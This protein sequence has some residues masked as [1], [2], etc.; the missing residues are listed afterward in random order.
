METEKAS[1]RSSKASS[2]P[3]SDFDLALTLRSGQV[4][5]WAALRGGSFGGWI[6]GS[7]TRVSQEGDHLLVRGASRESARN[8]F[9]LDLDLPAITRQ[10]DVDPVIREALRR[11]PGLRVIRQDPWE[12]T[13]S[14]LLSAYNNIPRLTGM[15]ETLSQK[16]G[17]AAAGEACFAAAR[18]RVSE[19]RGTSGSFCPDDPSTRSD[20]ARTNPLSGGGGVHSFPRPERLAG[21]SERALRNCG[22]GYRA[23]YLK[24]VAEKVAS[25]EVDLEKLRGVED[26]DL[27]RALLALPGIGQKV[28]ECVMLFAYA[29][30]AA[31]PVDV[32][33]GRAMRA[34][35][36]RR[37]KVTDRKI[38]VF[39][40]K[41]FGP[42]CGW[43]QQYLYCFARWNSAALFV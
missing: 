43:A 9:S 1:T 18:G 34:W 10:F 29:R 33:I 27:R 32:W 28:A 41:H 20:R 26:D 22:L 12:C 4:F 6:D 16:F 14:F 5:R 3:R 2:F 11:Y 21:V 38:R 7:F 37:R 35:Y 23:P 24:A 31:F 36:F 25:G 8:F 17:T 40:R 42:A 39:A 19:L 30:G 15:L 13:A